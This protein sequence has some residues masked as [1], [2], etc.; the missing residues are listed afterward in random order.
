M[1][2][3]VFFID[4][5]TG[6][7]KRS[8]STGITPDFTG[9]RIGADVLPITQQ[10]SGGSA[11]FD[12][13]A[14]KLRNLTIPL[15]GEVDA[16]ATV[17]F[18]LNQVAALGTSAEWQES[19]LDKLNTP[20]GSPSTGDRYLVD[21]APTGAWAGQADKIAEWD[22]SQWVFT[23]ATTGTFLSVDD[24]TDG[25]YYFGGS[26]WTKKYFEAT[27]ASE[28]IKKVGFDIQRDDAVTKTN[29]NAGAITIRQVVYIK[30]NGNVDLARADV[31][32]LPDAML[33]LVEDASI[34]AAATG[35]IKVRRGAIISGFIGLTPG[36]LQY[37][38]RTTAGALTESLSG[39]VAGEHV[40]SVGRAISTTEIEFDPQYHYEY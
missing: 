27:T 21:T 4:P 13:G 3:V 31:A 20:P 35:K 19:V 36:K 23:T 6:K 12:F 39:F 16:A 24:E 1:S 11:A 28:G 32:A 38:S 15:V 18:V 30:S 40:M 10:G 2:A 17:Q 9:V 29:D 37:V 26:S 7:P 8:N 22:G 25:I 33:G 14:R 5:G 34:S